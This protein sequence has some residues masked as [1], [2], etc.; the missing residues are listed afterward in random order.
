MSDERRDRLG[1]PVD[2]Q[3]D[4]CLSGTMYQYSL[5]IHAAR[6]HAQAEGIEVDVETILWSYQRTRYD[7]IDGLVDRFG[8]G[9]EALGFAIGVGLGVLI[10]GPGRVYGSLRRRW[11][12]W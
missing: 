6:S 10:Y 4:G 8:D 7:W 1:T 9:L 3:P 12:P 2:E 11:W 5:E